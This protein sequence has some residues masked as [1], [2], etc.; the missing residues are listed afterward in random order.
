[1]PLDPQMRLILD[2]AA[3]AGNAPVLTRGRQAIEEAATA[4]RETFGN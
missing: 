3:A 2:K 1:V 4:L